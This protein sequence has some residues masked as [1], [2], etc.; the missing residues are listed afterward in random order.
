MSST[1]L[2]PPDLGHTPVDEDGSVADDGDEE[3]EDRRSSKSDEQDEQGRGNSLTESV[4]G[5]GC[6]VSVHENILSHE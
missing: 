4:V 3:P 2:D 6:L 5:N 1:S